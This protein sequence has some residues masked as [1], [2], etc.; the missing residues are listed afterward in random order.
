MGYPGRMFMRSSSDGVI[1]LKNKRQNLTTVISIGSQEHNRL[2]FFFLIH[3][4]LSSLKSN[5]FTPVYEK[6]EALSLRSPHPLR[7]DK[8]NV[9][10][11][12]M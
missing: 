3:N 7:K 12:V 4:S 2:F 5:V 9:L 6:A 8:V 1:G 11:C 10:D